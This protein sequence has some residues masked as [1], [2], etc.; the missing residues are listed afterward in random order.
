[1]VGRLILGAFL[2]LWVFGLSPLAAQPLANAADPV[3]VLLCDRAAVGSA[4][5]VQ[6]RVQVDRILKSARV[7]LRW[8][9]NETNETCVGPQLESY[10]SIILVPE[11]PKDLPASAEALGR[12]VLIGTAY[13]RAY[14][15]LDRVQRFDVANRVNKPS[16]LGVILGHAISHELGHMLGLP[17]TPAGIMRAQWGHQEWMDAVAGVLVFARPDFKLAKLSH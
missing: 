1:M 17:H 6:A 2:A 15:F 9:D 13:P 5:K 10:L 8:L 12:A 7:Q 3:T 11:R 16:N 14:V 4:D